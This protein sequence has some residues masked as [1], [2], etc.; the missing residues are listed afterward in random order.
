MKNVILVLVVLVSAF[1]V[2]CSRDPK[3]WNVVGSSSAD[4]TISFHV[5]LQQRNVDVLEVA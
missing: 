2:L 4:E 3:D 1:A 5:A